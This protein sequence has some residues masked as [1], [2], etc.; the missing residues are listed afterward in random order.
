[1]TLSYQWVH[2]KWSPHQATSPKSH[3][4]SIDITTTINKISNKHPMFLMSL[5]Y[6]IWWCKIWIRFNKMTNSH[7]SCQIKNLT[8]IRSGYCLRILI[9]RERFIKW[10]GRKF[11]NGI[12]KCSSFLKKLLTK[13]INWGNCMLCDCDIMIFVVFVKKKG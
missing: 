4:C 11:F 12:K 8:W 3:Y 10:K 1:M 6:F 9:G 5:I 13:V 7:K 2:T